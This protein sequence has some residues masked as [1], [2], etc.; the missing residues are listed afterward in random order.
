MISLFFSLEH[1]YIRK[2]PA[3]RVPKV[4]NRFSISVTSLVRIVKPTI[5]HSRTPN[6]V[7]S[8]KFGPRL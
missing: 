3:T 1:M 2:H 4:K 8:G 6:L 7:K 5:N